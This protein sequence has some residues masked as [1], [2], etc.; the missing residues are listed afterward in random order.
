MN[1]LFKFE[2]RKLWQQKSMYIVFGIGLITITLMMILSKVMS[3]IADE[4]MP[5][6]N[7]TEYML[8]AIAGSSF[9]S[10]LG[11]FIAIFVC[12]DN[13]QHTI[14]NIY[15]R[16]Y[17]RDAVFFSKYLI[18]LALSF[19]VVIIYMVYSFLLALVLGMH[20]AT[21]PAHMWGSLAL[22]FWVVF[23]LHGLYFG[24]SMMLGKLGGSIALN[25]FG[26]TVVFSLLAL[27]I[28]LIFARVENFNFSINDY[29]LSMIITTLLGKKLTTAQ[30]VRA[31]VMPLC[32]SGV[33]VT[34]G[35]LVN[36][37][38]EV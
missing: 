27:L 30:L 5:S 38:R 21:M 13:H 24:L 17:S 9:I 26:V 3:V 10:L 29:Q 19:A 31:L 36:R 11:I 14:K 18:S 23:G 34:G 1:K 20:A 28:S 32:Y 4:V 7:A 22:Q 37:R 16:G 15:A 12:A 8:S 25:I 35:W 33:F 6:Q 2:W